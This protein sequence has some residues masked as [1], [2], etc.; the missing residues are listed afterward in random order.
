MVEKVKVSVIIPTYNSAKYV[1]EAIDSV[2]EQTYENIEVFVIDD[3]STDTTKEV[4][5]KY[6]DAI[7]YLYKE[8]GGAS[9][10]RNYG[11]ENATGKYIAFLDADDI[12]M[13]E[14]VEKQ[15]ALMESDEDIGL[16]Y[17]ST[18]RVSENLEFTGVIEAKEFED[19]CE[20]LLLNSNIVS[21]SCSSVMVRRDV[22]SQTEGFDE[23]L[24]TCGDWEYWLR[25]SLVTKFA[26]LREELA[27]YR[28]VEGSMSSNPYVSKDCVSRALNDF[29]SFPDLPG[30]YKKI[31]NRAFSNHFIIASGDFLHNSNLIESFSCLLEG[32]KLYPRNINRPLTLPFRLLKRLFSKKRLKL[33]L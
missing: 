14:K 17:V 8:N 2:L 22:V 28:D 9:S 11:I 19:Y 12:W 26:P 23:R 1:T 5:Q 6:G 13:P 25:L 31:E 21:G 29:F 15:V 16:C 3:G 32:L 18:Q 24:G 33:N 30:R 7:H 10:A 27:K 4:L 20:A